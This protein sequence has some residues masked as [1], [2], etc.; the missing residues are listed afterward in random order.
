MTRK[1]AHTSGPHQNREL[2]KQNVTYYQATLSEFLKILSIFANNIL[3]RLPLQSRGDT[4]KRPGHARD[5]EWKIREEL[6]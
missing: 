5:W 1:P 6:V 3:L 2:N 4:R